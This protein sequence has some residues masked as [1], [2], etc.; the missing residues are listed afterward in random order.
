MFPRMLPGS[1]AL[2]LERSRPI[3]ISLMPSCQLLLPPPASAP[4]GQP[5]PWLCWSPPS[6]TA[7]KYFWDDSRFVRGVQGRIWQ[8]NLPSCQST[9]EIYALMPDVPRSPRASLGLPGPPRSI[10]RSH[11]DRDSQRNQCRTRNMATELL[12]ILR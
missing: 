5:A 7:S 3:Y 4:P 6:T 8:C 12:D 10:P 11:R 1:S 9:I 2:L